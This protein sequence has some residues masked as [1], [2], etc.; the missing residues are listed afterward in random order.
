MSPARSDAPTRERG[1]EPL[2]PHQFE[3]HTVEPAPLTALDQQ[4]QY[5][6]AAKAQ[7]LRELFQPFS[8][9]PLEIFASAPAHFRMRAEFRIWHE[10]GQS[11]YAMTPPGER[12]PAPIADFPIGSKPMVAVMPPLLAAINADPVLRRKLYGCEFLTTQPGDVLATLIYHR[13]LDDAWQQQAKVLAQNLGIDIIGRSKKQKIVIGRDYVIETLNVN[14]RAYH[15][16]QVE[17]GFT[18]PNAGVNEQMLAWAERITANSAGDLL[19]LYCGNGNFT[20]VL[21][22]NFRKVLATE[23]AKIS[24]QSAEYNLAANGVGNV[25]I[26][27][28]SSEEFTQALNGVR[29][30]RRL[31]AIDLASYNFSTL[32]VDPPRAGLDEGT[33]ALAQRFDRILY[34]SCNPATLKENLDTLGK[35]HGIEAFALFDQFPYTHHAEC[36]V[37]LR[38]HG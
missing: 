7:Q 17:T 11:F 32:F 14:G 23:V 9:P 21:S 35:T 5:Q 30:F 24:V 31:K 8:P 4:Y 27:R 10:G 26:A 38:K 25:A 1:S 19:E 15:Y 33:L 20:L 28:M 37:L 12:N 22:G 3:S 18:Q 29:P 34:I 2:L 36:G 13:P 16:Q 6:L